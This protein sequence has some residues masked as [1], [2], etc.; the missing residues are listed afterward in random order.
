MGEVQKGQSMKGK[1]T[2]PQPGGQ[3]KD[4]GEGGRMLFPVIHQGFCPSGS[5]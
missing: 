1:Q 5:F 2:E 4:D 3:L